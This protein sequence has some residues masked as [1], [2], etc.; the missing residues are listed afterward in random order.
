MKRIKRIINNRPVAIMVHG[1]SIKELEDRIGHLNYDWCWASIN[2]FHL[3]EPIIQRIGK[4]IELL[5][6]TS[7]L[8][9][10][11]NQNRIRNFLD[12]KDKNLWITTHN[13]D[14]NPKKTYLDTD[15]GAHGRFNTLFAFL[16]LLI[17][18][19]TETVI[20]F[21]ADGGDIGKGAYY[22]QSEFE[23]GS[24]EE[25]MGEKG[26]PLMNDTKV[27]DHNFNKFLGDIEIKTKILNVSP[28]SLITSFE[29][30]TYDQLQG[31]PPQK[32]KMF[33]VS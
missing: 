19:E 14:Y 27:A 4:H 13:I 24:M 8:R 26:T 31:K 18:L 10:F 28:N 25:P 5:Y 17:R 30:I 20:L 2:H 7:P 1:P 21:G 32:K 15:S 3:V 11:Q 16:Y 23:L 12:R 6:M 33:K 9:I 29:K 22:K